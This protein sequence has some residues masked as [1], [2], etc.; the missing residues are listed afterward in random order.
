MRYLL[1]ADIHGNWPALEAVLTQARAKGFDR[2]LMLGDAVGYYPDGELV[3]DQ[4]RELQAECILGNHDAWMLNNREM[5]GGYVMDIL[6]W[7]YQNLSPANLE[8][9]AS[10]PSR[11]SGSDFLMVHG[12]PCDDF[13]YVD[14]LGL[15]EEALGCSE[16]RWIFHGHTHLAGYF[17]AMAGPKGWWLRRKVARESEM[18][19]SLAAEDRALVNPGSVGQP[20]DGVPLAGYA[21][22]DQEKNTVLFGRVKYDFSQVKAR[23]EA[24]GFPMKL[25][26][27]LLVGQ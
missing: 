4:L 8:F 14:A 27:R 13:V 21:I 25:Y 19:L 12:S 16:E 26:D 3:L 17:N 18:I 15:A 6:R 24:T 22:W 5:P 1:L 23:L 2:V 10:W 7:Q 9:L 11:R 20:R